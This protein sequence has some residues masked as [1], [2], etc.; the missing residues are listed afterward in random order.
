MFARILFLIIVILASTSIEAVAQINSSSRSTGA[1]ASKATSRERGD[2]ED[3]PATRNMLETRH[4][5]RLAA[6]EKEHRELLERSDKAARLSD[7]LN[8]SFAANNHSFLSANAPKLTELEKLIKKIRK[9]LGGDDDDKDQSD[10][11]KPASLS[12]AFT[13]LS[14]TSASLS[15]ELKKQTRH[16]ISAD[17]IGRSNEMLDLITLIRNF[18]RLK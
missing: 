16:E 2:D 14:Q 7:E 18:V 1:D 3:S 8:Q 12:E 4:R 13:K 17:S 11:T 10:E 9:N 6:E 15:E 5:W